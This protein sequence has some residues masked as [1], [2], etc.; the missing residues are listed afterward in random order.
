MCRK[1]HFW[2]NV[3]NHF[4]RAKRAPLMA[5]RRTTADLVRPLRLERNGLPLYAQLAEH[6]RR[7]IRDSLL[8]HAL[9]EYQPVMALDRCALDQP[10]G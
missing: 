9:I 4:G 5:A 3:A 6:L 8:A 7:A 2:S 10:V 1:G